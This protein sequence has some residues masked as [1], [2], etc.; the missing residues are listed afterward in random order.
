MSLYT[1][2]PNNLFDQLSGISPKYC[3]LL[4]TINS[5]FSFIE[6]WFTDQNFT[7]LETE[8]KINWTL[9][10]DRCAIYKMRYSTEPRDLI[11]VKGYGLLSFAKNMTKNIGKNINKNLSSQYNQKLLDH[12][13]QSATKTV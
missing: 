12:T 5:E 9:F 7:P 13:K 11:F 4:K 6:T 2:V 8:E 1:F 10:N 3:I